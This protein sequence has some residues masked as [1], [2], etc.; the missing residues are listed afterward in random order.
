MQMKSLILSL[1]YSLLFGKILAWKN[2]Y[3]EV[4]GNASENSEQRDSYNGSMGMHFPW[5]DRKVVHRVSQLSAPGSPSTLGSHR[6]VHLPA[7]SPPRWKLS[8]SLSLSL[9][10]FPSRLL[11][12]VLFA[13][14]QHPHSNP[15]LQ[16]I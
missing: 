7:R 14:L 2:M 15:C 3:K 16:L 4:I 11:P 5:N 13:S 12:R 6:L 9:S 1:L 10:L 8:L